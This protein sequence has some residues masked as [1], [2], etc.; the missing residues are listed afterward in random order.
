FDFRQPG[1]A[2]ASEALPA[3]TLQ[4][5]RH[6][7]GLLALLAVTRLDAVLERANLGDH[8]LP[9][10]VPTNPAG[11][12]EVGVEGI[13]KVFR[14]LLQAAAHLVVNPEQVQRAFRLRRPAGS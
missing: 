13:E 6:Q 4:Q 1:Q 3:A 2:K 10:R 8:P 5:A 14:R 9:L 12:Y 7:P 11:M